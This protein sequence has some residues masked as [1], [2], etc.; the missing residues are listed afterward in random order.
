MNKNK[1]DSYDEIFFDDDY[2][3][4]KL[5]FGCVDGNN[6]EFIGTTK[7]IR[8]AVDNHIWDF[9]E[10]YTRYDTGDWKTYINGEWVKLN[11]PKGKGYKKEWELRNIA[12]NISILKYG[13]FWEFKE[14]YFPTYMC[15]DNGFSYEITRI[16]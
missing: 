9:S 4:F 16:K 10:Y 14:K 13:Y 2:E 3:K 1:R 6:G 8:D 12:E 15:I 11:Y 5:S 7:E